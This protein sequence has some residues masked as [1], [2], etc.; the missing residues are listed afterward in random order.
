MEFEEIKELIELFSHS[1]LDRL[2]IKR[3]GFEFKLVR[4]RGESYQESPVLSAGGPPTAAGYVDSNPTLALEETDEHLQYVT[5][6]I[7]GTYYSAP[8]PKAEAFVK[9]GSHVS[10][11]QTL[12]IVE[13]MKLMNEIQSDVSGEV[14]SCFVENAQPIEYGQRLFAIKSVG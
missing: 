9:V 11:G 12:C 6:P 1:D 8:N 10:V 13:A 14:V 3:E 5:S 2:D 7:V 4:R